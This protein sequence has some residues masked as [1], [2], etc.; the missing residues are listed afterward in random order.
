MKKYQVIIQDEWNNLYHIGFYDNLSDAIPD[1]NDWLQSYEVSIDELD[2]YPST[3]SMCFDREIEVYDGES[4]IY[5]RGF[6]FD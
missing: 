1:V 2:E 6:I 3:F 4:V 5:I